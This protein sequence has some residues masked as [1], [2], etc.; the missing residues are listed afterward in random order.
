MWE[1][2]AMFD[3]GISADLKKRLTSEG[4]IILA[5]P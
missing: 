1:V 4:I 3:A 5:K 2:L